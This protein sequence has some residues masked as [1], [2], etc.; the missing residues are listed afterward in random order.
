MVIDFQ[1]IKL[2]E[3]DLGEIG[4]WLGKICPSRLFYQKLKIFNKI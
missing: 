4:K 2:S 1:W 3:I